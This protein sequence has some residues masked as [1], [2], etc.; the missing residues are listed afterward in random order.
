MVVCGNP[1]LFAEWLVE[2]YSSESANIYGYR[3]ELWLFFYCPD[4]TV[5]GS[6][7]D[8]SV[9]QQNGTDT[10]SQSA[11]RM[12]LEQL[13]RRVAELEAQLGARRQQGLKFTVSSHHSSNTSAYCILYPSS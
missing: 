5:S 7:D 11:V 4:S 8:G 13:K 12:E 2:S 10:S 3:L 6:G 9:K 1:R